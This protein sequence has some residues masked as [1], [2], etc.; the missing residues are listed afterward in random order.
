MK[1]RAID[2]VILHVRS[3]AAE[4][5]CFVDYIAVALLLYGAFRSPRILA[6]GWGFTCAMFYVAFFVSLEEARSG[7]VMVGMG[8]LSGLTLLDLILSIVACLRRTA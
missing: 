5:K 6:A 1:A 8:S 3:I 4:R 7:P 2:H